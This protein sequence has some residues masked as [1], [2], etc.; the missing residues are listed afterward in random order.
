MRILLL[1]APASG[2][3][4][5]AARIAERFG[6]PAISTGDIFRTNIRNGTA[7]GMKAKSFMDRGELV[8]DGLVIDIALDRLGGE[9][10]AKGFILDGFPRTP[11]QANA[12][13]EHLAEKGAALD[14]ALLIDTPESELIS[15]I[16]GRRT[17][18]KCGAGYHVANIPPAREGICDV[19]GGGLSQRDDDSAETA[20]KRIGVYNSQTAPLIEHYRARGALLR[21]DGAKSP[22]RVFADILEA[23]AR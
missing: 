21:V 3:G 16:T 8:P 19:C 5:Q 20:M 6:I 10:C 14:G 15:R 12:L 4:T 17:C 13:D 7:L 1:G 22:D 2:K 9:D 11:E 18:E 23:L